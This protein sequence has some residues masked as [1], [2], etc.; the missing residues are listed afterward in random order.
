MVQVT[1]IM[2]MVPLRMLMSN[3]PMSYPMRTAAKVAAACPLLRPKIMA[4]SILVSPKFFWVIQA[5]S[6]LATVAIT[7]MTMATNKASQPEKM[8]EGSMSIPTPMRK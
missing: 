5:A 4:R 2:T 8:T 6:H 3:M 1:K 7:D